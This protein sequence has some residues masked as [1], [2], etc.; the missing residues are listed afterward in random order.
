VGQHF[1]ARGYWEATV[2]Q[3]EAAVREY[4][5]HQEKANQRLEQLDR[6]I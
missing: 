5:Q 3:N 1:R 6:L 2:G 4:I